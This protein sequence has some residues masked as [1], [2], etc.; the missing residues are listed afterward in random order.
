M[1][2]LE[3]SPLKQ[4]IEQLKKSLSYAH[5]P[6]AKEDVEL[7]EQ[8]RN[9]SIQ[10]FEFSYELCWKFLKRQLEI[11]APNPSLI[12]SLSYNDLIRTGA[13]AGLIHHPEAWFKYRYY[14]NITAHTYNQSKAQEIY[15]QLDAFLKDSDALLQELQKRHP[16]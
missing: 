14:R 12:D 15:E 13:E 8:F 10:C 9:S 11:N 3:L 5:S 4:A 7:F 1:V 6:L 2:H 16:Q